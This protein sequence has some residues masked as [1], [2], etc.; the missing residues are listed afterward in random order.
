MRTRFHSG[1][2]QDLD[3]IRQFQRIPLELPGGTARAADGDLD[4]G[5]ASRFRAGDHGEVILDGEL[6]KNLHREGMA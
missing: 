2:Y 6:N 3:F 4:A 1:P 5:A